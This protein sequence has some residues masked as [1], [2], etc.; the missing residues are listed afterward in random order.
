MK[1]IPSKRV[2]VVLRSLDATHAIG[3]AAIAS[4]RRKTL[5]LNILFSL[6]NEL[7]SRGIVSR[8]EFVRACKT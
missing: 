3:R 7:Q 4:L 1:E 8:R 5:P 6:G 2:Q